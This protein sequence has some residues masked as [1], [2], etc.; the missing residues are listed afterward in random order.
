MCMVLLLTGCDQFKAISE[1]F[2]KPEQKAQTQTPIPSPSQ[3]AP[4]P[5]PSSQPSNDVQTP[6]ASNVLARVGNW[7]ITVDEFNDRLKAV[8][9]AVP[10][11]DINSVDLKKVILEELIGQQLLV[12][13]G[14]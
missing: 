2:H 11:Y 9:E 3:E 4:A 12:G 14:E 6:L 5:T 10:D 7:S 1:Y 13:D 8:K